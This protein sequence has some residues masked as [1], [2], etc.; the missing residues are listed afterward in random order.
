MRIQQPIRFHG[1]FTLVEALVAI[2]IVATA[3]TAMMLGISSAMTASYDAMDRTIARGMAEQLVDEVA[4]RMYAMGDGH[5]ITTLGASGAERALAGR[6]FNDIDDFNG[7]GS[8]MTFQPPVDW[9]GVT[10]GLDDGE[11]DLR[12][13]NFRIASDHFDDWRQEIEVY[14]VNDSD[15]S[16]R[17]SG[18][19]TS[20]SRAVEVRISQEV[21]GGA[22][23]ELAVARRV[24]SY[25]PKP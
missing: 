5:H 1:G 12:H 19:S 22:F 15:P 21:A 17:L 25:I 24:F 2:S 10:L 16:I 6:Q 7:A 20:D 13:P 4:G 8:G 18:S 11:G 14:Y 9:Q 3:G 23:R